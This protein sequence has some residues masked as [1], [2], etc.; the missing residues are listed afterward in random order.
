MFWK[1][2]NEEAR[3]C[4]KKKHWEIKSQKRETT[5]DDQRAKKRKAYLTVE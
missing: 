4:G 2:R 5:A 3:E 1:G